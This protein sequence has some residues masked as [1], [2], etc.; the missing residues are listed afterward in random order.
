SALGYVRMKASNGASDASAAAMICSSNPGSGHSPA[1]IRRST[2]TAGSGGPEGDSPPV[3]DAGSAVVTVGSVR[4]GQEG[5]D[6]IKGRPVR[7]GEGQSR[8]LRAIR[9][10]EKSS[11]RH[12]NVAGVPPSVDAVQRPAGGSQDIHAALD[13]G[14]VHERRRMMRL[15]PGV[16]DERAGA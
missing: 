15:D 16:D 6:S 10:R 2:R 14:V 7:W 13:L 1:W 5:S 12:G 11:K 3:E 9:W 4:S 8:I